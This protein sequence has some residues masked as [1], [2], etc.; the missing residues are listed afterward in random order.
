[1]ERAKIS[2]KLILFCVINLL[3]TSVVLAN[4]VVV[5]ET[6]NVGVGTTRPGAKLEIKS[7]GG[8]DFLRVDM[9]GAGRG[10]VFERAINTPSIQS[11]SN[12]DWSTPAP[13][14]L[15][16]AGGNVSVGTA[17]PKGS[18]LRVEGETSE[19]AVFT[20]GAHSGSLDT[21][22]FRVL[23]DVSPVAEI[24]TVLRN[25]NV[26][27]GVQS[28]SSKLFVAGEADENAVATIGAGS[29]EGTSKVFRIL[30][31]TSPE[32]EVFSIQRNGNVGIGTTAPSA[33]LE[34][35]GYAA[36]NTP[37]PSI[38]KL[39]PHFGFRQAA[40]TYNNL[41]LDYYNSGWIPMMSFE[42]LNG[43]VGIGTASPDPSYKLDVNGNIRAAGWASNSDLRWKE[44]I[45]PI[46]D[47]L[48]LV[49]QLRGVTYEWI[50][51]SK[52][53]G[54]QLGVIAQEVEEVFPQV[55]RTD[56]IGYKSVEYS[57]LVAPLIEAVKT[58]KSENDELKK[59]LAAVEEILMKNK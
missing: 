26:G 4:D 19:N 33:K 23:R 47:S 17:D 8:P 48:D 18:S 22:V 7:A 2:S 42:R 25:G 35:A 20:V 1:V 37:A 53:D 41:V 59:R 49:T 44:N 15:Q 57:K 27:I 32:T 28:P 3:W 51:K 34:I 6:G 39:T 21:K 29:G 24:L 38:L 55:V 12:T 36:T 10:L 5:S 30:G 46:E 16:G 13:L 52:G 54:Q 40:D 43:N 50:D 56:N 31:D 58:L 9:A 11:Y 45:E 14:S